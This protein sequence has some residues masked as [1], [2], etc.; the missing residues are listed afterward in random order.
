M[1]RYLLTRRAVKRV[2]RPRYPRRASRSPVTRDAGIRALQCGYGCNRDCDGESNTKQDYRSAMLTIHGRASKGAR[3][4]RPPPPR[5]PRQLLAA[6]WQGRFGAGSQFG[7]L[8]EINNIL[9][10]L[11]LQKT[12]RVCVRF[13]SKGSIWVCC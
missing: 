11:S 6:R 5:W 3:G 1:R 13:R 4:T 12:A 10:R 9:V 7:A 8:A 2:V